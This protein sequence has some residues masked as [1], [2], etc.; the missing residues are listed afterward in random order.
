MHT[1][2]LLRL[3]PTVIGNEQ[4]SVVLD[5]GALQLVLGVLI[6]VLLVVSDDGLGDGLADGVDLRSLTTTGDAD[7]DVDTGEFVDADDQEGFVDLDMVVIMRV[8]GCSCGCLLCF[9]GRSGVIV[10]G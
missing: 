5:K 1:A 8:F 7:A 2:K 10:V 6:D 4:V 3:S 9:G